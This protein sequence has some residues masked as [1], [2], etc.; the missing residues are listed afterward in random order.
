[1]KFGPNVT[2]LTTP[3]VSPVITQGVVDQTAAVQTRSIG[4]LLGLAGDVYKG[5]QL[6]DVEKEQEAVIDEYMTRRSQGVQGLGIEAASLREQV[7]TLWSSPDT[8]IEE[9]NPI[10]RRFRET[11][12]KYQSALAQGAMSPDEFSTRTLKVLREAVNK[13]PGMLPELAKHAN[14]VLELSGIQGFLKL[15]QEMAKQQASAQDKLLSHYMSEA[16]KYAIDIP[17]T[18]QG[19]I[20]LPTLKGRVDKV[21]GEKQ[22]L[23][24]ADRAREFDENDFRKFGTTYATGKINQALE[25]LA[26]I[27]N[28][29]KGDVSSIVFQVNNILDSVKRGYVSDPRIGKILDKSSVKST[30]EFLNN[31]IDA[32]KSNIK[33]F[34]TKEEA[35]TFLKNTTEMLRNNQYVDYSNIVGN[36]LYIE[37]SMKIMTSPVFSQMITKHPDL[38]NKYFSLGNAMVKGIGSFIPEVYTPESSYAAIKIFEQ[39]ANNAS[40]KVASQASIDGLSNAIKTIE[41]DRKQLNSD[42]EYNFLAEYTKALGNTANKDAFRKISEDSRRLAV[43]HVE[44]YSQGVLKTMKSIVSNYANNGVKIAFGVLPNGRLEVISDNKQVAFELS[45]RFVDRIN[46]SIDAYENLFGISTKEVAAKL[47]Y[48]KHKNFFQGK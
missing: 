48:N 9:I 23:N 6:A 27:I 41:S 7:D 19:A 8:T 47:F 32:I 33:S 14:T 36:P 31:Q 44:E 13:N 20:D 16:G 35:A 45:A 15:D 24:A 42:Q 34:K 4:E 29:P 38:A 40:D 10:E 39:F 28:D 25:F 26:P 21:L 46:D 1:M 30:Q 12:A 11:T 18:P 22:V 43:N 5:K 2:T 37:G 3:Q 17:T